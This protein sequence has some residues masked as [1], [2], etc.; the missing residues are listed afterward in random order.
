MTSI[1]ICLILGL[2][3]GIISGMTG[4]GGGIIILPSLIFLL[5]FSQQQAQ[6]TTLALLVLPIDLL[7]AWVYYKQGYVDIKV[8]TLICLGFIF[9]GW[10]GAKVGTNLP[11]GALS[12]IFAIIMIISAIKV[13]F[14]NPAEGI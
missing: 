9:G 13:F 10:L 4:I 3:A 7:A 6:G 11:P 1:W 12:K 2:V 8:A 5:G 14:T